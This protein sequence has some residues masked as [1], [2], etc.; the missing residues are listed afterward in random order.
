MI[1]PEGS[2]S[3]NRSI[4]KFKPGAFAPGKPVQP[5]V[6]KFPY[7]YFNPTWT[8]AGYGGFGFDKILYLMC[9]QPWNRVDVAVLPVYY[10]DEE[11]KK[12][13]KLYAENVRDL[14]AYVSEYP[15]SDSYA[16]WDGFKAYMTEQ[17]DDKVSQEQK[18]K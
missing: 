9:C 1:F 17:K 5:I 6:H 18:N 3:C 11:E 14:M 4:F 2:L 16:D 10:P 7:K 8:G 12:D 13:S 15:V